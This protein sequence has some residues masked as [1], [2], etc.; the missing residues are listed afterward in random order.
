MP[1]KG[2][3]IVDNIKDFVA[4]AEHMLDDGA[5]L[6]ARNYR[7]LRSRG[8]SL[9]P[10]RFEDMLQAREALQVMFGSI[11]LFRHFSILSK[12]TTHFFSV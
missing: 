12:F 5:T 8:L 4:F 2:Q 11:E 6:L 7:Y 3:A 10:Q 1:R 9:L